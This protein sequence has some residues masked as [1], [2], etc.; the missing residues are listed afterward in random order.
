VRA[1]PVLDTGITGRPQAK[2]GLPI[3]AATAP[4]LAGRKLGITILLRPVMERR[5]KPRIT[6]LLSV[7]SI[8]CVPAY[9]SDAVNLSHASALNASIMP[10]RSVVSRI[11]T[12]W[13]AATSTH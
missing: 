13:A 1:A 10:L 6:A 4:S 12:P 7:A 8:C 2:Q 3:H 5:L 11:I 9:R